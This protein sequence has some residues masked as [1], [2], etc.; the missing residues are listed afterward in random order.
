MRIVEDKKTILKQNKG[1][2]ESHGRDLLTLLIKSNIAPDV[3]KDEVMTDEEIFGRKLMVA[4]R[5]AGTYSFKRN[6]DFPCRWARN[7]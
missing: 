6:V 1:G 4:V 2:E 3:E 5:R 7:N